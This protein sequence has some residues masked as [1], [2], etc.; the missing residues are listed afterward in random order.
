MTENR[1]AYFQAIAFDNSLPIE[2]GT[3]EL[4][5]KDLDNSFRWT[6]RPLLQLIFAV[7]LHLIWFIKRL[8]LPQ[9]RAPHLLQTTICWFCRNFVSYEAN[10]LILRHYATESNILNFLAVNSNTSYLIA[11]GIMALN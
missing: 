4:W 9:F 3:V 5:L 6:L 7:L 8:P 1:S 10:M 11:L 2:K